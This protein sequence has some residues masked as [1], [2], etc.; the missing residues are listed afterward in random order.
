MAVVPNII[1]QLY[2]N[3]PD[4]TDN[5]LIVEIIDRKE[6][7]TLDL[8]LLP[9][10]PFD[11]WRKVHDYPKILENL[12]ANQ[13]RFQDWMNEQKL[14]DVVLMDGYISSFLNYRHMEDDK[15]SNCRLTPEEKAQQK[16][17]NE[18][19]KKGDFH[20]VKVT[21]KG[22]SKH[23]VWQNY[24]GITEYNI[25]V[26]TVQYEYV[27][28]F[29]SYPDWC[30]LN[31]IESEIIERLNRINQNGAH[32]Q[33]FLNGNLK[34][35]KMGGIHPPI[36]AFGMLYRGKYLEFVN[37]S[38]L[39]LKDEIVFST[40]GNLEFN[41]CAVDNLNCSELELGGLIF[42]NCSVR[43]IKIL[44]SDLRSWKFINSYTTGKISDSLLKH[45]RI[46]GGFFS[47]VFDNS[48]P[49]HFG[50][51]HKSINHSENFDRTYRALY[52]ANSDFGNY[53]EAAKFKLLELDFIAAKQ[54]GMKWLLW[55]MNKRYWG[56][57][58]APGRIL[59]FTILAIFFFG[60]IYSLAPRQIIS[61]D[62]Y[63]TMNAIEKIGN[64]FYGSVCAFVTLGYSGNIVPQGVFKFVA[65]IEAI[66][67]AITM[68]F[69][70]VS[71]TKTKE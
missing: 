7:S 57:G 24:D 31:G 65:A 23:Q 68:G 17:K 42:Q 70:V 11:E 63:Q 40:L 50:V 26:E 34:L 51:W 25:D 55:Q 33:V 3:N 48:D 56:Y 29:I 14:S 5:A 1:S 37:A 44:N 6:L 35:L 46:W 28:S 38:G 9:Q 43:N 53:D 30:T 8:W 49:F 66:I 21:Y 54:K 71:L 32:E 13:P 47:P 16:K 64:S 62:D 39:Q 19:R 69:L 60:I 61:A 59:R 2:K 67:G 18:Y 52:K 20:L 10:K 22:E 4:I 58:Y 41:Y 12:K 45:F 36:N 15:K 27:L